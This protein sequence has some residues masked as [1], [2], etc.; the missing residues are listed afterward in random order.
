VQLIST[1]ARGFWLASYFYGRER[2]ASRAA[3]FSPGLQ[4]TADTLR[5]APSVLTFSRN[6]SD[7]TPLT[8]DN[9]GN[10]IS[11]AEQSD[12][13]LV[14]ECRRHNHEAFAE[15][16][17]RYKHKVYWLV[18]RML[19]TDDDEDFAQ[20][21]FLRAYQALPRFRGDC[22]FSTWIYKITRNLCLV[23]IRKRDVR[24]ER[25]SIDGQSEEMVHGLLLES[26][27]DLAEEIERM[28]LSRTVQES[29]SRLPVQYRTALTLFY[30]NEA[31][32][33]EIAEIMEIPMGTVKTYI[34]RGRI[35]LRDI[36]LED[37][38]F[39]GLVDG[40]SNDGVEGSVKGD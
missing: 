2:Y 23:E 10:K 9:V 38:E 37:Q 19:G 13:V 21:V 18:R 7:Y 26:R 15:L 14:R 33:E 17:N 20:E 35:R 31:S 32:Y 25:V 5:L 24:G 22:K 30:L 8:L 6:W 4:L 1:G 36:L 12:E 27:D 3:V 16:V 11:L 40:P 39:A 28:E 34:H 29:V